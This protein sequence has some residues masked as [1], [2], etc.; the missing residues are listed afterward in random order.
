MT[1][2]SGFVQCVPEFLQAGG[3]YIVGKL[4]RDYAQVVEQVFCS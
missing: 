4:L 2:L 3:V 1:R